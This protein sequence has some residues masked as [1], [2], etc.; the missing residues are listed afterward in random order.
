MGR[1]PSVFRS[2]MNT[3]VVG[4][5]T[6]ESGSGIPHNPTRLR[7]LEILNTEKIMQFKMKIKPI[8][9]VKSKKLVS[10]MSDCK[11]YQRWKFPSPV[12][13][14]FGDLQ[15]KNM[16]PVLWF[17]LHWKGLAQGHTATSWENP[18]QAN[19]LALLWCPALNSHHQEFLD[20]CLGLRFMHQ[21]QCHL[22]RKL[23]S[24]KLRQAWTDWLAGSGKGPWILTDSK[25]S[26]LFTS[27][28]I[29]QFLLL[30]WG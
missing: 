20:M 7:P 4:A 29:S 24:I 17:I 10:R 16:L 21:L 8:W 25:R 15:L 13:G 1:K 26:F 18:A 6:L 11:V 19:D 30:P 9:I 14:A 23:E 12:L 28:G 5:R 22:L 27:C 2:N 3:E